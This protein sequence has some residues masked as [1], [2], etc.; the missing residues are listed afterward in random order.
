[1]QKMIWRLCGLLSL[2]GALTSAS[3]N[4]ADNATLITAAEPA[5]N[6]SA[7]ITYFVISRQARPLQIEESGGSH[8]GIVTDLVLQLARD[9]NAPVDIVSL[10]FRRMLLEMKKDRS[11][12]WMTY[13]SPAWRDKNSDSEQSDCLLSHPIL[14]VTHSLVTRSDSGFTMNGVEDL[15]SHRII[16]LPASAIRG[17]L[18]T[19]SVEIFRNWM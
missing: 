1:M 10:P 5:V 16:T 15:F 6:D 7:R 9:I 13:G 18:I 4:A 8:R 17:L 2:V 19:S 12:N 11:H 14:N 3:L